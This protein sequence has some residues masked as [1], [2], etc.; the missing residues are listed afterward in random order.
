M[1]RPRESVTVGPF[2]IEFIRVSHSIADCVSL[3][4]TTPVGVVIHTGDFKVDQ[5]PV[6]GEVIDYAKFSEYGDKG[7]LALLSDST[8]VEKD[9]YTLSEREVGKSFE[10]IFAKV[11]GPD[12]SR[13][14]LLQYSPHTA[15][16]RRSCKVRQECHS[17]WPVDDK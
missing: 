16:D 4:I 1:V 7:V 15:G 11:H 17:Q 12:N 6:D 9:G 2:D 10:E 5:T 13:Y 8:N 14:I 3:A